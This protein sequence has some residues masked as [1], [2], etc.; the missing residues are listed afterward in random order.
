MHSGLLH[1]QKAY[2]PVGVDK[3]VLANQKTIFDGELI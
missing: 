2:D 3:A 1:R